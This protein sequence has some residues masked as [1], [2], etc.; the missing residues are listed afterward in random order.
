MGSPPPIA[1]DGWAPNSTRRL[2]SERPIQVPE[3]SAISIT[4]S[5]AGAGS[6]SLHDLVRVE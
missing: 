3:R 4:R 5:C 1:I 6:G 2:A